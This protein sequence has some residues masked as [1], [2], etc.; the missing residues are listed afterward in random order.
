MSYVR[1][2]YMHAIA[3]SSKPGSLAGIRQSGRRLRCDS[4]GVLKDED[5]YLLGA[6][7]E[8]VQYY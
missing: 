1:I 2:V 7:P 4:S 3:K 6:F 8:Y 5:E